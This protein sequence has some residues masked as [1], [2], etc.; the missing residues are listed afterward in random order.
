[1]Y[2]VG[3]VLSPTK[4]QP[5]QHDPTFAFSFRESLNLKLENIPIH[6]EHDK[7]MKVG[8]IKK[9]WTKADG[10]KWVLGK[11]DDPS[12]FGAFA[13]NA[14]KKDSNGTR[15]YTGL[16]L[17]H[18]HTQYENGDTEKNPV[19]VSL[20]VDPRRD[21]CRIHFVDETRID[22]YKSYS[23][24]LKMS[25][26]KNDTPA[27]E[28][29][30]EVTEVKASAKETPDQT[31]MM[32]VIVSQQKD[33]ERLELQAKELEEL[34]AQIAEKERKELEITRAKSEA[35]A[36]ALVET[37][38]KTLDE[39]DLTDENRATIVEMAKKFPRESQEFLRVAHHASKKFQQR[40][41]ELQEAVE[42]SKN[43]ELKE[44][45]NAVM[46]KTTHVASKKKPKVKTDKAHF[47]DAVNK[48]RTNTK[49]RAL[50]DQRVEMGQ[51]RR[52]MF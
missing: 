9:S 49:G 42:A 2:F 40:E 52:R 31:Q 14:M 15:Y 45:F 44:S 37:W 46:N 50:L 24:L 36:N 47:M 22:D 16:S 39:S 7:K 25:D 10:S 27:K 48:Y 29:E 23:T 4:T 51:K 41:K 35:M 19:E 1:M 26:A 13:R 6:M 32:E 28:T 11:I 30:P 43:A 18:T 20:C 34:K 3:N 17:T 5:E 12:M 8:S 33:L 38:S 21:D